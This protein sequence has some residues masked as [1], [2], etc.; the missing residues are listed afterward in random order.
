MSTY[1]ASKNRS[2]GREGWCILFRHPLRRDHRSMPLR[3]RRGL[4]T[5]DEAEADRLVGQ[6]NRLLADETFWT[7]SAHERALRE[8]DPRVVSIFYDDITAKSENPWAL[9]EEIIPLPSH[10]KGYTRVLLVGPTGAGKTTLVRQL[11]GTDPTK[12][13]F[14]STSTAKTTVFD[15][16]IVTSPG[17][18]RAAVSFLSRDRVRHYLEE[19]VTAAVSAASE[20]LKEEEITRR[21]LEHSEQRFR[22]SYLLGTLAPHSEDEADEDDAEIAEEALGKGIQEVTDENRRLLEDRL[23]SYLGRV[24][25]LAASVRGEVASHL[26]ENFDTMRVGDRDVFLELLEDT[27]HDKEESH[28]LIDDI[29]DDIESRFELLEDGQ[30]ERDRSGWPIRWVFETDDRASF[31]KTVNRFSSNYA[32]N[33]GR[34]LTPLVQGLRVAGP[35]LPEW[36]QGSQE[37]KLVLMD[38]EGLGHTPDTASSLPTTV[39]KRYEGSDVILL[40][41]NATQPMAAGSLTVLRSVVAS[42]H[43]S[44]LAVVFTH[45][46]QVKGDN[47]PD[48]HAKRN[49]VRA[50]LDNAINGVD[51][52]LGSGASRSL[53]RQL[54]DKVFY[55]G[56]IDEV[57]P[58]Q[59]RSIR[60][61][62]ARLTQVFSTAITPPPPEKAM[63]IY[64][65]ANLILGATAAARQFQDAWGTRLPPEHWTRVKALA[66]RL[67][68]LQEDQYDTLR[69]VAD[70]IAVLQ[71]QARIFI[72]TPR[73]WDPV[74]P[75]EEM[76][77]AAVDLVSREFFTRLHELVADR[78][79][80][81]QLKEWQSAY[82]RRGTGSGNMR[83]QDVKAIHGV[84]A[85]VPGTV[86]TQEA[87]SFLDAIRAV[88]KEAAAV[89][90]ARVI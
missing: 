35:F 16:E 54:E 27:L 64:D 49:H 67:G 3:V 77:Q 25:A 51:T 62:L 88:F 50:S 61:Q 86:P 90:G 81:A 65:L 40:V 74:D 22:M 58:P 37:L 79:W 28:S 1:Q 31:L 83:K 39:T 2:Q 82:D 57:L 69:P 32:P 18:Y 53:R 87:V 66:R 75:P 15:I 20:G 89:A 4:G 36:Y 55:V 73:G 13:R 71:E 24:C 6:M 5:R 85:P 30:I 78:L 47:I 44:K 41:D 70:L 38:G 60:K 23:R 7:P 34:L 52:A 76:R 19:C 80:T 29:L 72:L 48:E 43:E 9:R 63:P 12:E 10:E 45:F 46:D 33:F 14:P 56:R 26:G 8:F 42:G 17:L 59:H 21:L 11:I 84:A 68:Y